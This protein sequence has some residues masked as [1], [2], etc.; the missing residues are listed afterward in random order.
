VGVVVV[1][2]VVLAATLEERARIAP[3]LSPPPFP[4]YMI[5]LFENKN[6]RG[7]ARHTREEPPTRAAPRADG[8]LLSARCLPS[9]AFPLRPPPFFPPCP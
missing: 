8:L 4:P 1:V 5:P 2:V 7:P 6:A 3:L 9:P